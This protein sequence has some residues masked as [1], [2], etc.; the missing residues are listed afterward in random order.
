MSNE[1][2]IYSRSTCPYCVR[3]KALLEEEGL[4]YQEIDLNLF[5][6][7]R[8]EMIEKSGGAKTVPQVFINAKHVGGC[9]DLYA[10]HKLHGTLIVE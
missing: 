9:D 2:I 3:A 1:I 8:D 4:A 7:K 5:P 10:Y 6:E